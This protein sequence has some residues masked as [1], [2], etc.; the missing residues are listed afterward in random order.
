M[1]SMSRYSVEVWGPR[2]DQ[3]QFTAMIEAAVW[4]QARDGDIA[5]P[6]HQ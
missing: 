6:S 4:G 1:S 3:D 2:D 5:I